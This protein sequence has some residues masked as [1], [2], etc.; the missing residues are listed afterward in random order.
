[1]TQ[2]DIA[3]APKA[4]RFRFFGDRMEN[5][6][7]TVTGP[8]RLLADPSY[9]SQIRQEPWLRRIIPVVILSFIALVGI[10]RASDL[11]QQREAIDQNARK[12]IRLLATLVTAH[13]GN[14]FEAFIRRTELAQQQS[15]NRITTGKP[16]K[17][18]LPE[19]SRTNQKS[20]TK[21]DTY[22]G[23]DGRATTSL[24]TPSRATFQE[25][26]FASLPDV[27]LADNYQ[28]YLTDGTGVIVAS[29]P[30]GAQN[31]RKTLID[32][33]G[34]AQALSTFGASAGVLDITL[35]DETAAFAAVHHLGGGRGSVTILRGTDKMFSAW[36]GDVARNVIVFALMSGIIL[37]IVYAFF[38]QGAR[39]READNIYIATIQ[40]MD[41]SLKR[42]RS[43]LWDWDLERGHIYWSRSMYELL[44][45]EPRDQL[46]GFATINERMHPEDGNLHQHVEELLSSDAR[47][48]DRQFR[49]RHEDGHWVCFQIRAELTKTPNN[50]LHLMGVAMDVTEQIAIEEKN[51]LADL[52]LRDAVDT[53]SEAFVLWDNE[54]KLVLCNRPYRELH[55]LSDDE[56]LV[57]LSYNE[58]MDRGQPH[59]VALEDNKDIETSDVLFDR[60]NLTPL[61]ARAYKVQLADGRWLQISERRTRDGGFVS[62][63]TD[64]TN[65]KLQENNLLDSEQQ[66]IA[67]VSDLRKS[68]Q[69]LELQAQQLV[70]LTEQYAKEKDNAEVAN[71]VKSQFLANISH[72]LRTPLN[73]IIGFSEVMKQE[74]FGE[75]KTT[76]YRDYSADIHS[77]G[78]YLL[79]LID[80]ILNMSRL[81][82]GEVDLN[83]ETLDM[84]KLV[85]K[86]NET[87][88]TDQ[89]EERD[90]TINNEMPDSLEIFADP[91]FMEQVVINLLENAVKFTPEGGE[92]SLSGSQQDGFSTLT[93]ADTG[94]GIPQDAIDRL[95]HP[96]EQVQNQFTKTH[97][98]SGLGLSIART[99]V[100]LSGGTMKIRSRIGQ[101]TRVTIRLPRRSNEM[102][103]S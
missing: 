7:S 36:R 97:Q 61:E 91:H 67:T 43:G 88:I 89:A 3:S 45:M 92:I 28:I 78:S 19:G 50:R 65:L 53:I 103:S 34:R 98:G 20:S 26:L 95:G 4:V 62:V 101:G 6:A 57:G 10:W 56:N 75:H 24:N 15:S 46:M 71:R 27:D 48:M 68:R 39:A 44:G 99:I 11:M 1:M 63:G 51:M 17:A 82:D 41:A 2:A 87:G 18:L 83:S 37:L 29:I 12:E 23:T 32:L 80:D 73:A 13:V 76:K 30:R 77:S 69:T 14:E 49:I 60:I 52:R 5:G 54:S 16:A 9:I 74:I 102:L 94:V 8:A 96:F 38:S 85:R 35:N 100:C 31:M 40:R 70:V 33:L 25:W 47:M 72:E 79:K 66:L 21:T 59:V 22:V 81:E 93:I 58:V 90:I 84:V 55:N 86:I 64:I 42:S